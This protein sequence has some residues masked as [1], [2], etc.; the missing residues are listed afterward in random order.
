[1]N[2]GDHFDFK[3]HPKKLNANYSSRNLHKKT[4]HFPEPVPPIIKPARARHTDHTDERNS[5]QSH[6]QY[7]HFDME[8]RMHQEGPESYGGESRASHY[9]SGSN[10]NG[11]RLLT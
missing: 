6:S 4:N 5:E 11:I 3:T 8:Q 1:M 7:Q 2:T 10:E 9:G